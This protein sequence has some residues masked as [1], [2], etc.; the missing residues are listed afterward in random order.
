MD[1]IAGG[2][3]GTFHLK[4]GLWPKPPKQQNPRC[5]PAVGS[6]HLIRALSARRLGID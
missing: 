1:S 5:Q 6:L 2:G 4:Y 3:V